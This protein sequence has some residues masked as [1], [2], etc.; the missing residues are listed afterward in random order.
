MPNTAVWTRG[1]DGALFTPARRNKSADGYILCVSRV[2]AEKGLDDFCK[3]QHNN[4]VLIGDGPYLATL[5]RKY[6]TVRFLGKQEGTALAEWYANAECF[7][8]PSKSDTFGIVILEA[9]ASG[10]PVAAY[11]EPGPL[12]VIQPAVNGF[13]DSNL[14][15]ALD[16][17]LK[18]DRSKIKSTAE[19]WTW[20][21][22]AKQF[23]ETVSQNLGSARKF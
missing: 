8:F 1:V 16:A 19:K 10:V 11:P 20:Q 5:K 18:I 4:K 14:Q 21:Y 9:I 2:S 22:S 13:M 6:P 23:L 15:T 17:C 12:E 3:L 7:V